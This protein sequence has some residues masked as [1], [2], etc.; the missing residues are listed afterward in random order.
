M[1]PVE[2]RVR[3]REGWVP[4]TASNALHFT[5]L[6]GDDDCGFRSMLLHL[7]LPKRAGWTSSIRLV[8]FSE[9]LTAE[10]SALV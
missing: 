9:S 1:G 6:G 5:A 2:R 10:E 8:H 7:P 4:R 3:R